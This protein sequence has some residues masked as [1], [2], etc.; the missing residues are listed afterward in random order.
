MNEKFVY[1]KD[2]IVSKAKNS[3]FLGMELKGRVCYTIRKGKFTYDR[4]AD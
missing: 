3:P 2:M 1:N 4:Q